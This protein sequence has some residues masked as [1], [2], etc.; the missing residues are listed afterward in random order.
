MN[1]LSGSDAFLS[2]DFI[3][4]VIEQ[5]SNIGIISEVDGDY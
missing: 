4:V 2:F 5:V 1:F 3:G